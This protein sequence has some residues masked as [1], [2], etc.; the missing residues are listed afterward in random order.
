MGSWKKQEYRRALPDIL[1]KGHAHKVEHCV[2]VVCPLCNGVGYT[3]LAGDK[4]ECVEC[5][6]EG[7]TLGVE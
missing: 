3:N 5:F 4:L 2:P 7:E 1:G 6:G